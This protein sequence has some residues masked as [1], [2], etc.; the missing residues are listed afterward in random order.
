M[1]SKDMS[2][3]IK[4]LRQERGLTLEQVAKFIVVFKGA[5]ILYIVYFLFVSH[6]FNISIK[7]IVNPLR[8]STQGI[9]WF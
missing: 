7:K 1:A 9:C 5:Y 4:E 3:K 2:I 8:F 6:F